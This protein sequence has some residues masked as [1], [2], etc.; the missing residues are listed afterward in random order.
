[1]H[2]P[3]VI[4]SRT[5]GLFCSEPVRYH[6]ICFCFIEDLEYPGNKYIGNHPSVFVPILPVLLPAV[7]HVPADPVTQD[8]QEEAEV[9]VRYW[10][11]RARDEAPSEGHGQI[12][13]VVYLA[14]RPPPPSC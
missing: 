11:V 3:I 14:G 8:R 1:M 12:S 7:P 2:M 4:L 6:F 9:E 5:L 13:R 10:R